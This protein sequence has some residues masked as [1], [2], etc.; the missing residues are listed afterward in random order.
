MIIFLILRILRA[1][2]VSSSRCVALPRQR[3]DWR[4]QHFQDAKQAIRPVVYILKCAKDDLLG[5][6]VPRDHVPQT[7]AAYPFGKSVIDG[8]A[9]DKFQF[10]KVPRKII[11]LKV[12]NGI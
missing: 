7:E 2:L 12:F 6:S 1:C 11:V 3:R 4:G 5:P 10:P 9:Q 8:P